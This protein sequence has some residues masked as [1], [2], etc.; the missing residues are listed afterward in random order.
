MYYVVFLTELQRG[1]IHNYQHAA[2]SRS[3]YYH[4]LSVQVK[5]PWNGTMEHMYK[6]AVKHDDSTERNGTS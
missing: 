6:Q 3:Q 4:T 1:R 5:V 2:A